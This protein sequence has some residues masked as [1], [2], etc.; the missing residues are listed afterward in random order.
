MA[1][2]QYGRAV[3]GSSESARHRNNLKT[4]NANV[5]LARRVGVSWLEANAAE[6]IWPGM[7]VAKL[8]CTVSGWSFQEYLAK[9]RQDREWADLAFLHAL[10]RAHGVN[11]VI[12]QAH[13]DETLVGEDLQDSVEHADRIAVPVALVNDHYFWGSYH[14][15]TRLQWM[16]STRVSMQRCVHM[17]V[18][19]G[20]VRAYVLTPG[21]TPPMSVTA[22]PPKKTALAK[23]GSLQ[24]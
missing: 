15:D 4:S 7:T 5:V 19:A 6:M 17:W 10:G 3:V 18:M 21:L 13:M 9:M 16:L 2:M 12:F 11:V 24:R 1:Q 14:A 23:T 20:G 22:V 8:C